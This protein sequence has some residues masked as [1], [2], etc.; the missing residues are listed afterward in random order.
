MRPILPESALRRTN[1]I[2]AARTPAAGTNPHSVPN[3]ASGESNPSIRATTDHSSTERYSMVS[4]TVSLLMPP[5][6]RKSVIVSQ[7]QS[8]FSSCF[9]TVG[10]CPI[11]G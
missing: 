10:D 11:F 2:S 8:R 1:A 6:V 7:L 3:M 4:S 5:V 9:K